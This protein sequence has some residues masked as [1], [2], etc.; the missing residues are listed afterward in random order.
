MEVARG[1]ED[2]RI[3]SYPETGGEGQEWTSLVKQKWRWG[4][5]SIWEQGRD[6]EGVGKQRMGN[7]VP[8]SGGW[9]GTGRNRIIQ[10]SI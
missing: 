5:F 10:S 8:A 3:A 7:P 1:T 4:H 9:V 6:L 2:T